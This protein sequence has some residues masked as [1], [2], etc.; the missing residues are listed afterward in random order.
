MR[1]V[2]DKAKKFVSVRD[3]ASVG[4]SRL[5]EAEAWLEDKCP[6]G[7]AF[8]FG[9]CGYAARLETAR[10]IVA[11]DGHFLRAHDFYAYDEREALEKAQRFV[12]RRR[13]GPA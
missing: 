6:G 3:A 7:A 11:T 13:R 10:E 2:A 1:G 5:E 8:P 4:T 12:E 9:S